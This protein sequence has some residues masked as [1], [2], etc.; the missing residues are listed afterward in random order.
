MGALKC[1]LI[2]TAGGKGPEIRA[3]KKR[4]LQATTAGLDI[5]AKSTKKYLAMSDAS[6]LPLPFSGEV[7]VDGSSL[8]VTTLW[9]VER[10]SLVLLS[11]A[12]AV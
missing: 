6:L 10:P 11:F 7:V 5:A 9:G 8:V 2:V 1:S 3:K 12:A 4:C